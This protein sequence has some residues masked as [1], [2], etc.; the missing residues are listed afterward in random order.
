MNNM[1][2]TILEEARYR[3]TCCVALTGDGWGDHLS[4][5]NHLNCS[6]GPRLH[7]LEPFVVEING[8]CGTHELRTDLSTVSLMYEYRDLMNIQRDIRNYIDLSV[9]REN[10]QLTIEREPRHHVCPMP[11][12]PGDLGYLVR[13][14]DPGDIIHCWPEAYQTLSNSDSSLADEKELTFR[15]PEP[16]NHIDTLRRLGL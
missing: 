14:A 4:L 1:N 6:V 10:P 5:R 12:S 7:E 15:F 16:P 3:L 8:L 9:L 11:A 13:T 2:L